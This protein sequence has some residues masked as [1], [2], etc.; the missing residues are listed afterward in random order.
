VRVDVDLLDR[1]SE[2]EVE[3]FHAFP[4]IERF[5][6]AERL[7]KTIERTGIVDSELPLPVAGA[8]SVVREERRDEIRIVIKRLW[9]NRNPMKP[10]AWPKHWSGVENLPDRCA[11][12][13]PRMELEY[14][15]FYSVLSWQVHPGSTGYAGKEGEFFH[16]L[17]AWAFDQSRLWLIEALRIAAHRLRLD[18]A[19]EHFGRNTRTLMSLSDLS[20]AIAA[21]AKRADESDG[22]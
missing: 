2:R 5:R 17:C 9:P 15:Q 13:G 6:G 12:L 22:P 7:L 1:G 3:Q 14:A 20:V 8:R 18:R 19:V 10:G 11:I 21:A 4:S 16:L